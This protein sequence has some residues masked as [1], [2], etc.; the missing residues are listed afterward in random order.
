M[1]VKRGGMYVVKSHTTGRS[2]GSYKK[3]ADAEKRLRQIQFFSRF[4]VGK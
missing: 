2:F 1:I 4:K 3:K